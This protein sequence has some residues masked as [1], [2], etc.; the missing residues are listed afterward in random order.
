V[1]L[2]PFQPPARSAGGAE[3][4]MV[5]ILPSGDSGTAGP[6]P[7]ERVQLI[8]AGFSTADDW[9]QEYHERRQV[10]ALV[11]HAMEGFLPGA[12]A[13]WNAGAAGAHVCI[14]RDGT[15]VLSCPLEH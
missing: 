10:R 12:L 9:F 15:V 8:R 7:W 4:G 11:W 6:V 1:R 5:T 3:A 14:L 2:L 13:R